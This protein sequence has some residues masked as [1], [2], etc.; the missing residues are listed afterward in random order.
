MIPT[1]LL[2]LALQAAP[3]SGPPAALRPAADEAGVLATVD[4]VFAALEA[5]AGRRRSPSSTPGN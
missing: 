5:G 1:I 3:L 2:S 4:A